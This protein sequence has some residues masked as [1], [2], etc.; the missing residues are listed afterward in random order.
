MKARWT[1]RSASGGKGLQNR[2]WSKLPWYI[3]SANIFF[4]CQITFCAHIKKVG[5][6]ESA[7]RKLAK[8]AVLSILKHGSRILFTYGQN[9]TSIFIVG[10]CRIVFVSCLVL[11]YENSNI[12]LSGR[13]KNLWCSLQH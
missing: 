1:G 12:S 13:S 6:W 10:D 3:K 2:A 7:I 4:Y 5:A 8:E 11:Y 9:Y